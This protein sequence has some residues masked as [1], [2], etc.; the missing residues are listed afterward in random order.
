MNTPHKLYT[1]Y[2]RIKPS[3]SS[4]IVVCVCIYI[5][6]QVGLQLLLWVCCCCYY[7]E[8]AQYYVVLTQIQTLC[9]QIQVHV[10]VILLC[11][12]S[13]DLVCRKCT[14]CNTYDVGDECHY[15]FK[16]P[17]FTEDRISILPT[18]LCINPN[19]Y[20]V[21]NLMHTVIK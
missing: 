5:Y 9:S 18:R 3:L 19:M 10:C 2:S 6:V 12:S 16:F 14:L 21:Q 15:I 20:T 4:I 17:L 8:I 7:F 11:N 13:L 1:T